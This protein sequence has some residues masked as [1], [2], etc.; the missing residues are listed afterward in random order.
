MESEKGENRKANQNPIPQKGVVVFLDA[1]GTKTVWS[2]NDPSDYMKSWEN[3]LKAFRKEEKIYRETSD[4]FRGDDDYDFPALS[5]RAFSDTIILSFSHPIDKSEKNTFWQDCLKIE[6]IGI[7]LALP[8]Y[9]AIIEEGIYLRGAISFGEFYITDSMIIGPAVEEAAEWYEKPEWFGIS[10]TPSATYGL[11][12]LKEHGH[13]SNEFFINYDVPMK[14]NQQLNSYAL[15]WPEKYPP[16]NKDKEH[17]NKNKKMFQK[18]RKKLLESFSSRGLI[19]ASSELKYKN[20]LAFFDYVAGLD[21]NVACIQCGTKL[22]KNN[23]FCSA[24]GTKTTINIK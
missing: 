11:E 21:E 20:T 6:T 3:V 1:V 5:V 7:I 24:C 17:V 16:L 18:S 9:K 15:L 8:L 13:L 19:G 2:R 12:L 10:T 14:N 22:S 23:K 4:E